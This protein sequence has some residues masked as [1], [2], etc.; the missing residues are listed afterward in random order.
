VPLFGLGVPSFGLV[1][2]PP[3]LVHPLLIPC[4]YTAGLTEAR[5]PKPW[6]RCGVAI[7]MWQEIK[8]LRKLVK[9]EEACNKRLKGAKLAGHTF[10]KLGGELDMEAIDSYKA[11]IKALYLQI[12]LRDA[13]K[14]A[15]AILKQERIQVYAAAVAAGNGTAT[16]NSR[17]GTITKRAPERKKRKTPPMPRDLSLAHLVA[18]QSGHDDGILEAATRN[19]VASLLKK[20]KKSRVLSSPAKGASNTPDGKSGVNAT[21]STENV[22]HSPNTAADKHTRKEKTK[23]KDAVSSGKVT[24]VRKATPKKAKTLNSTPV[25][26]P[27]KPTTTQ[28]LEAVLPA[29]SS[30]VTT[31]RTRSVRDSK[32][33]KRVKQSSGSGEA[34]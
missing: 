26:A 32:K 10:L 9:K 27:K 22:S 19:K 29:Q 13:R 23:R 7:A 25:R 33:G 24:K 2:S 18:R 31:P 11:N 6:W 5:H 4:A 20:K 14:A 1:A 12:K 3:S 28:D 16:F 30:P 17:N 15:R 34:D 21:T 8:H